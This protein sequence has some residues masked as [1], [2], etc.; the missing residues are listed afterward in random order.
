VNP[1]TTFCNIRDLF[2]RIRSRSVKANLSLVWPLVLSCLRKIG[3]KSANYQLIFVRTSLSY[4]TNIHSAKC[5][6]IGCLRGEECSYFIR[7]G[8]SKVDGLD[9]FNEVGS[10]YVHPR[11]K[12]YKMSVENMEGI[13][14]NEYDLVHCVATMEHV[15]R[16][17]MAF[18]EMVRI[19]KPGGLIYCFS[20]PL[21]NSSF[22]H[23]FGAVFAKCPWIHLRM[24]AE[25]FNHYCRVNKI[26]NQ[27]R[28]MKVQI[29]K[30]ND[31]YRAMNMPDQICSMDE[32]IA[33]MLNSEHFNRMPA[34]QYIEVCDSLNAKVQV[35]HNKLG[36]DDKRLLIPD[37]YSELKEKGYTTEELL[38]GSHTFVARKRL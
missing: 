2:L 11:V 32:A 15:L 16:I 19:C 3:N 17:D 8:A 4:L 38:A 25:E 37:I 7:F 22:G 10:A 9:V 33:W 31:Y 36:F 23:H 6:V 28:G 26:T 18:S 27:T 21:W 24:N 29:E 35:I 5:M 14:D 20:A 34:K 12:Y 13:E 1:M 30:I